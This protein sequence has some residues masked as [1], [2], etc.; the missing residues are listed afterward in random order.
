MKNNK[1]KGGILVELVRNMTR[2]SIPIPQPPVGGRPCSSLS[3]TCQPPSV[4]KTR[5]TYASTKVSSIPWASSS[6]CSFCRT[7]ITESARSETRRIV[8][9]TY[10]LLEAETLFEWVVKFRVGIAKFLAAHETFE[11]LAEARARAMPLGQR[12]HHLGMANWLSV[13]E[14]RYCNTKSPSYQ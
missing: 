8:V 2:R 10:L 12:G 14:L 5:G 6:P 9:V 1:S 7:C 3:K 13:L 4:R 11:S